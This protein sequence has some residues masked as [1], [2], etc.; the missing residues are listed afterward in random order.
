MKSKTLFII[1]P[2]SIAILSYITGVTRDLLGHH[3][4][5]V[6]D[7]DIAETS[8][9]LASYRAAESERSNSLYYKRDPLA[10]YFAGRELMSV[11][12]EE[13]FHYEELMDNELHAAAIRAMAIDDRVV[14]SCGDISQVVVI[15]AGMDTRPYRIQ[16]TNPNVKWF[17]VDMPEVIKLKV[18]L[19]SSAPSHLQG[20]IS[21]STVKSISHIPLNLKYNLRNLIPSLEANGFNR[22]E[23]A[24]YIMEGLLMY[25]TVG[26]VRSLFAELPQC[27]GSRVVATV[28]SFISRFIS[29]SSLFSYFSN[30]QLSAYQMVGMWRNDWLSLN[31]G[32][33][34]SKWNVVHKNNILDEGRLKTPELN[35][36]RFRNKRLP[37]NRK[38]AELIL[39]LMPQ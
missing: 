30:I 3:N 9:M 15:G 16:L 11:A 20:N 14:E 13:T 36:P 4:D 2:V 22:S 1:L 28:V 29:S 39:D 19:L 31:I 24:F 6:L 35:L 10:R 18:S 26:D 25:L 5:I 21:S 23:P 7:S 12:V 38:G 17:E 34:F 33:A 32:F 37:Q 8:R 27:K